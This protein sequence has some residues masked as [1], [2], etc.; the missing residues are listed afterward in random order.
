MT[1]LK[2]VYDEIIYRVPISLIV[3]IDNSKSPYVHEDYQIIIP[4][5]NNVF[6]IS[7]SQHAQILAKQIANHEQKEGEI[8]MFDELVIMINSDLY[9]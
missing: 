7:Q 1:L 9:I 2:I 4:G 5:I 6:P 3:L 8:L